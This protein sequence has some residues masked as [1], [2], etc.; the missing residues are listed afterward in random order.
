MEN[1]DLLKLKLNTLPLVSGH[2]NPRVLFDF[3]KHMT[4]CWQAVL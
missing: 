3:C 2:K 1:S 4:L